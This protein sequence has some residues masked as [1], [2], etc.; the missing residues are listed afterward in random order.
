MAPGGFEPAS[1]HCARAD[2]HNVVR[3]MDTIHEGLLYVLFRDDT[4][5][6][7]S[8]KNSSSASTQEQE[9]TEK[10]P[11]KAFA[12]NVRTWL[13][14]WTSRPGENDAIVELD[15]NRYRL[16]P[17]VACF[18]DGR[19]PRQMRGPNFEKRQNLQNII[20]CRTLLNGGGKIRHQNRRRAGPVRPRGYP[21]VVVSI[22][23]LSDVAPVYSLPNPSVRPPTRIVTSVDVDWTTATPALQADATPLSPSPISSAASGG[24]NLASHIYT[25][26]QVHTFLRGARL[27]AGFFLFSY[28]ALVT[29]PKL[30][31]RFSPR[32]EH[33]ESNPPAA[34]T[35]FNTCPRVLIARA[36]VGPT[37]P[38]ARAQA[39][40]R[41]ATVTS[42]A[43]TRPPGN[44]HSP[45]QISS[46]RFARACTSPSPG[47]CKFTSCPPCTHSASVP[48]C[49]R[50]R[51][52]HPPSA[53]M[54]QPTRR[55]AQSQALLPDSS[56]A[57]KIRHKRFPWV[58]PTHI[59][60][61]VRP[62]LA[63]GKTR[64]PPPVMKISAMESS[65]EDSFKTNGTE[66]KKAEARASADAHSRWGCCR[67]LGRA[68]KRTRL[69]PRTR[70][71]GKEIAGMLDLPTRLGRRWGL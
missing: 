61:P 19:F 70:T 67:A 24:I 65:V 6:N 38:S 50:L 22:I 39:G 63:P 35:P 57:R 30:A 25:A 68:G 52:P 66:G 54:V 55:H 62:Q 45:A 56:E 59:F 27:L 17:H 49:Y 60:G 16:G 23:A 8:A 58:P 28:L 44:P 21:V 71:L 47:A 31:L 46:L 51:L 10:K 4:V 29:L 48:L 64:A 32:A 9:R 7:K 11:T 42:T 2:I 20:F 12:E 53:R 34:S 13:G 36:Y 3:A 26:A 41:R 5:A 40:H 33:N 15:N 14:S 1:P 18:G 37:S 43:K 69:L